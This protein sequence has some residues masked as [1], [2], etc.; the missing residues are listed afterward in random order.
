M[1]WNESWRLTQAAAS[2]QIAR[3]LE[4]LPWAKLLSSPLLFTKWLL[5]LHPEVLTAGS[6]G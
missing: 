2:A 1:L 4:G 5:P 6:G 3:V